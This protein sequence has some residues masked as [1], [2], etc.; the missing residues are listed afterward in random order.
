[1][2]SFYI[3]GEDTKKF[4]NMLLKE[5]TFDRFEV[6]SCQVTT[7]TRIE[8]DGKIN[9]DF[10]DEAPS[11][12]FAPWADI[13][14]TVFFLIKGKKKP[15]DFKII[16]SLSDKACEKLHY[17]AKS[18]FLN[19]SFEN[20]R[21]IFTTGTAQREFALNKDLDNVWEESIKKFFRKLGLAVTIL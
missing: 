6:R 20:D 4:M 21:V 12:Y 8:I 19:I 9:K 17:N 13:R 3:E 5:S 11:G 10:Y 14:P 18:C 7:I 1:M 2:Y 15:K 16:L